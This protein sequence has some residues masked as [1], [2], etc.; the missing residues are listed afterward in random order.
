MNK[1]IIFFDIDGTLP[2][3]SLP[4]LKKKLSL[5]MDRGIVFG[6]NTG[7]PM[8][9]AK[10]IYKILHLNGPII[11][12]DGAEYSLAAKSA[13]IRMPGVRILNKKV[14]SFL[15]RADFGEDC[16][17]RISKDRRIL[18]K[19][20]KKSVILV[21]PHR[22]FTSSVYVK[23]NMSAQNLF[24]R[25]ERTLADFLKKKKIRAYIKRFGREKLVLGNRN[26]DKISTCA[27]VVKKYF[28][29]YDVLMVS[30]RE[31]SARIRGHSIRFASVKNADSEYK[32]KCVLRAPYGGVRGI[33]FLV[34]SFTKKNI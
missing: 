19:K 5:F 30:D 1:K 23:E 9:E 26:H 8:K 13:P 32:E 12:E 28:G 2:L 27:Y 17:V 6:I 4:A 22:I 3:E 33:L 24:F 34:H 18:R 31:D 15:M 20:E 7:R 11:A 25:V 10:T 21:T 14:I 29:L 16:V